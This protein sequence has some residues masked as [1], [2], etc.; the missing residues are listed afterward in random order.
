MKCLL[1]ICFIFI[2]SQVFGLS[3][4]IFL[5]DPYKIIKGL[6]PNDR[7][8][9]V[10]ISL[11]GKKVFLDSFLK[12]AKNLLHQS[13]HANPTFINEIIKI[14]REKARLLCDQLSIRDIQACLVDA[15]AILLDT[16]NQW[17]RDQSLRIL[18]PEEHYLIGELPPS[19]TSEAFHQISSA[20]SCPHVCSHTSI[21][22]TL[23]YGNT[24]EYN[25]MFHLAS[26]ASP[27]CLRLAIATI[28]KMLDPY[29]S[30]HERYPEI[31]QTQ[32]DL[33][34]E[35]KLRQDIYEIQNR[36]LK[37]IR[38]V[39]L[40]FVE[41]AEVQLRE[42]RYWDLTLEI[43]KLIS[44]LSIPK[45]CSDYEV[46]ETRFICGFLNRSR[47]YQ[48]AI[49]K[50]SR[51]HHTAF[52]A[53]RFLPGR[54][55]DGDIPHDQ[56]HAHYLRKVRRC[57]NQAYSQIKGL[58]EQK[59]RISIENAQTTSL[60]IQKHDIYIQAHN[61][62]LDA[63]NYQSDIDCPSIFHEVLHLL[64]LV[65]D[66]SGFTR[67]STYDCRI[68]QE[69]SIMANTHDLWQKNFSSSN[70]RQFSLL[71]TTQINAIVYG[72][73]STREDVRLLR[74]RSELAYQTSQNHPECLRR[75]ARWQ[76]K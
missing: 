14:A 33:L 11:G 67:S 18:Y 39:D 4:T 29:I 5:Y 44:S 45:Q 48:Y 40:N 15:N 35:H 59:L 72:H 76:Q 36:V 64:G 24:S 75:K 2:N 34:V 62:L 32:Q 46:Q 12:Q 3:T 10:R 53:M 6:E 17:I 61:T 51:N 1:F 57:M 47:M 30:I 71:T 56:L 21:A 16:Q 65:D 74:Q 31:E 63:L 41:M 66:Y 23:L 7:P 9:M 8:Y 52:V 26:M 60:N 54:W 50:D 38:E 37:L 73:C 27:L 68:P 22:H 42:Y 70:R 55:Y 19:I 13:D 20:S 28:K 69:D 25:Q 49:R 58:N 43:Q